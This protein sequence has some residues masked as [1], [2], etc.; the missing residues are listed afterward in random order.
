MIICR[1]RSTIAGCR[2]AVVSANSLG[3]TT[4]ATEFGPLLDDDVCHFQSIRCRFSRVRRRS[5]V[6]ENQSTDPFRMP[7]N[8]LPA[9]VAP[10][11]KGRSK[12]TRVVRLARR[13]NN[14][15]RSSANCSIEMA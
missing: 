15:T 9:D 10:H 4:Q 7:R 5:C 12:V 1:P 11:R 13:T 6:T 14:S 8:E 3:I 2:W